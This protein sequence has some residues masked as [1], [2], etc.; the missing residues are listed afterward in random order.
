MKAPFYLILPRFSIQITPWMEIMEEL[1]RLNF[2]CF[3]ILMKALH[4]LMIAFLFNPSNLQICSVGATSEKT[5][6]DFDTIHKGLKVLNNIDQN[7]WTTDQKERIEQAM[8]FI[9]N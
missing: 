1:I 8:I 7:E 9:Q 2:S 5:F 4:H 3:K 6:I